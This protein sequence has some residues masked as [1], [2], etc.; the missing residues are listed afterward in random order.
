MLVYQKRNLY[1]LQELLALSLVK[2]DLINLKE[3]LFDAVKRFAL[4]L[5]K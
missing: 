3:T 2:R 4:E 5:V 1:S